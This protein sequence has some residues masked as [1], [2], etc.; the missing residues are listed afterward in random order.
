MEFRDASAHPRRAVRGQ[1]YFH[2][3]VLPEDAPLIDQL[4]PDQQNV[5]RSEG[6]YAERAGK[7]G[8]PIGTLRS[9]LHRARDALLRLRAQR[10]GGE[11]E[12]DRSSL[13]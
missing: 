2:F 11:A 5:L 4:P 8:I 6:S 1:K 13:H 3:V 12:S 9:R 10:D 7:L